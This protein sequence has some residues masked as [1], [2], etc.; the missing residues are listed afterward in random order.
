MGIVQ[1]RHKKLLMIKVTPSILGYDLRNV[2]SS[3]KESGSNRS[4]HLEII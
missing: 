1:D 2:Y 3:S 4:E